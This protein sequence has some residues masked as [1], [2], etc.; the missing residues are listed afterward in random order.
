MTLDEL[1]FELSNIH[2]FQLSNVSLVHFSAKTD[3]RSIAIA[4]RLQAAYRYSVS[5]NRE[6][7]QNS[8][9]ADLWTD[10]VNVHLKKFLD[11][12]TSGT[13]E[14]LSTLLS[15]FGSEYIWF[16]G[17]STGI[18]S[19]NHRGKE[20]PKIASSYFDKLLKLGRIHRR[21]TGGKP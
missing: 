17:I 18:D 15:N 8:S 10:I 11:C 4:A 12:L 5:L 16:G 9:N 21:S 6:N 1:L 20:E 2:P 7:Q 19:S 13:P 14:E 3:E